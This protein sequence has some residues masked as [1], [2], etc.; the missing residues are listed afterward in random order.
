MMA[1]TA[2][3][4]SEMKKPSAS[5]TDFI[6]DAVD[7]YPLAATLSGD[8]AA[9]RLLIVNSA[10]AVHRR[11]Y[12]HLAEDFAGRGFAVLTWDY[13][14]VGGSRPP[15]SLRS[16]SARCRDF[17]L[18]DME[19]IVAWARAR[20]RERL[21]LL[22]HSLGGQL[23]GLLAD[24]SGIDAMVTLSS[25]SGYWRLQG[26][27]QKLVVAFHQ[28][29]T[30][31]ALSSV[32]GY[33]PWRLFGAEDLPAGVALEWAAWC[34]D[35]AYLMGDSTLPLER[36]QRFDAPV[37]AWSIDDDRW[38]TSRSVDTMMR[39]Y[40]HVERRHLEPAAWGLRRVGHFG[41]FRPEARPVWDAIEAWLSARG[42]GSARRRGHT[43]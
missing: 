29:V 38:G 30:L 19:A 34:R 42:S 13:R 27:E 31:P 18:K 40:P 39:A 21:F 14:G 37:L 36:Y 1:S 26:R 33:M 20:R 32:C 10:M 28:Y 23:A 11:F 43:L 15:G 4:V 9:P 17:V 24:P 5:P 8:E 12:R 35:P 41:A 7:G 25:Q 2:S 16:F 3:P 22:G 6:I